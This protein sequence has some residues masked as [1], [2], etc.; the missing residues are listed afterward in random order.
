MTSP[1]P[2]DLDRI[3]DTALR[4]EEPM[5]PVPPSL[6]RR[7]RERLAV[8]AM[9]QRERLWFR[10]MMAAG[11]FLVFAVVSVAALAALF[12]DVPALFTRD[13]PGGLG[14]YDY[15]KSDLFL[16]AKLVAGMVAVLAFLLVG[17]GLFTAFRPAKRHP[18]SPD[19]TSWWW[20]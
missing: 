2:H 18:K 11:G 20:A 19:W 8:I 9:I 14:Y 7:I 13:V 10:Y 17:L 3:I 4:T 12:A 15:L 1:E 5:R 6:Y 16:S